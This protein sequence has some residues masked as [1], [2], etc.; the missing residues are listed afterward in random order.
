MLSDLNEDTLTHRYSNINL[1]CFPDHSGRYI[2]L[3][4]LMVDTKKVNLKFLRLKK[5]LIKKH[6]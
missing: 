2:H 1:N 3:E 6:L 4:L 5:K